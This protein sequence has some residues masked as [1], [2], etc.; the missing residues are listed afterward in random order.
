MAMVTS[1]MPMSMLAA[2]LIFT[3]IYARQQCQ[4]GQIACSLGGSLF[5]GAF[6]GAELSLTNT[7]I[8]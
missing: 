4:Q 2:F 6:E 3:Y 1:V 5:G 8:K 7:A